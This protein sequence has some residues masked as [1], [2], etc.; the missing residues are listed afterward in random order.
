MHADI[1]E[2][3]REDLRKIFESEIERIRLEERDRVIAKLSPITGLLMEYT[4]YMIADDAD[5]SL[6]LSRKNDS[7]S[8]NT[9][10]STKLVE[11][12]IF[13]EFIGTCKNM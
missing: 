11:S 13:D 2:F 6:M 1:L 4:G 3:L 5:W 9:F 8:V 12:K 10:I 7:N